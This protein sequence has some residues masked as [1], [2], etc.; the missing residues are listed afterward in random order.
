VGGG[1]NGRGERGQAT[2]EFLAL[3]PLLGVLS[4]G[5]WQL[6]VAGHALWSASAVARS[7]SRVAAIGGDAETTVH[8][9]AGRR[10]TVRDAGDGAVRV[11]V[12]IPAVTGGTDLT[13]FTTTARFAP[14]R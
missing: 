3:L 14:Q 2:V 12:P 8:R 7:A 6:A 4:L 5:A 10:A 11:T 9:I 1:R 13:T